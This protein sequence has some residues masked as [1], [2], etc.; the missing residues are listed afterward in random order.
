MF[1][2]SNHTTASTLHLSE[3]P[4]P[5]IEQDGTTDFAQQVLRTD[6]AGMPLEWVGFEDVARLITLEQ[7]AYSHGQTLFT[8]HGGINADSGLRSS[9]DIPSIIATHGDTYSKITSNANY[10]PP[11][12]NRTLFKRDGNICLYCGEHF[13][14]ELLSRDHITPVS[15]GGLDQWQNVVTACKRCNHHK[16]NRTPEQAGMA[17]LAVPFAPTHAEYI[18][19]KSR[20]VLADQ[21][22]FLLSH[23]PRKS[24]LRL[25]LTKN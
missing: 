9:I 18:Y 17:L 20:R 4:S 3:A 13:R 23:F 22:D 6:V 21:M 10:T 15:K 14:K 12:S 5:I 2:S 24:P 8:I 11:L 19:L 25:R 1:V 16:A 7:I